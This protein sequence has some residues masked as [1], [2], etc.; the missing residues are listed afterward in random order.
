MWN[1]LSLFTVKREVS[2]LGK[3][4]Q[5]TW[6]HCFFGNRKIWECWQRWQTV[7]VVQEVEEVGKQPVVKAVRAESFS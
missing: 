1:V 7:L 6:R 3:W 2:T 4:R 5:Q